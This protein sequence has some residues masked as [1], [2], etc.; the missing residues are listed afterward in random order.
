MPSN[1]HIY[2]IGQNWVGWSPIFLAGFVAVPN[3]IWDL[4]ERKKGT[5]ILDAMKLAGLEFLAKNVLLGKSPGPSLHPKVGQSREHKVD[6][7]PSWRLLQI[8]EARKRKR[9]F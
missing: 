6:F 1:F 5:R 8:S 3:P 2:F 7:G 9:V 4:L